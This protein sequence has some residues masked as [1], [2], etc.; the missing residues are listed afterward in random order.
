MTTVPP[1]RPAAPGLHQVRQVA[2]SF[3]ADAE[4]YDRA[5][6]R[7]PDALVEQIVAA[8]P[9]RDFLDVGTGTGIAARQFQAAG[10]HVL[11][12]DPD[13]RMA[14][15][16][17]Q[18]GLE[19]E[20]AGALKAAEV[21]RPGGRVALFW[22]VLEPPSEV[23]E[24]FRSVYTRVLAGSPYFRG[25]LPTLDAYSAIFDKAEGGLSK[26]DAFGPPERWRFDWDRRYTR[27]EWLEQVPTFGGFSRIPAEDLASLLAGLG[28]AV[29]AVGGSF[30]AHYATVVVTT[31][32]SALP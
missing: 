24:A 23:R 10:C 1:S 29:D 2:E 32:R 11:G 7:Y 26:A 13:E 20:V 14:A 6:P 4:R 27:E 30:T 21:L 9:G 31:T 3:G 5:R 17:R 28:D 18:S 8:S 25:A 22:Y 16:A 19:T 12:I 15:L